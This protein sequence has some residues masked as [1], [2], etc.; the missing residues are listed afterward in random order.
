MCAEHPGDNGYPCAPGET[1]AERSSAQH[2]HNIPVV[3]H[4]Q[5]RWVYPEQNTLL[6]TRQVL[7]MS[8]RR[9]AACTMCRAVSVQTALG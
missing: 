1:T 4:W 6:F 5:S 8:C 9:D 2:R 7:R 3:G